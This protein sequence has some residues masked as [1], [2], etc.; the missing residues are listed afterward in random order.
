MT[1]SPSTSTSEQA[2][3]PLFFGPDWAAAVRDA[4]DRGPDEELRAG[5]LP[6]YWEW[7]DDVR[8][9]YDA[10]W[11]LEAPDL[12]AELGGPA[13]L[14]LQWRQG[15]CVRAVVGRDEGG[16]EAADYV[17]RASYEDWRAL[18]DGADA[19]RLLMC[20]RFALQGGEVLR[21]FRGVYF[22]VESLAAIGRV[23]ARLGR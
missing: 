18:L 10:T 1:T 2:T 4:V 20:R 21:F 6:K 9:Q 12:P 11:A 5:K 19:G 3:A 22:V 7:I 14:L 17:L 23:P 8:A 15:R 16:D 13:R